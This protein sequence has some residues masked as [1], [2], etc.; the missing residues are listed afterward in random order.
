MMLFLCL[1]SPIQ[2]AVEPPPAKPSDAAALPEAH[3][4]AM[5]GFAHHLDL[6]TAVLGEGQLNAETKELRAELRLNAET[7]SRLTK[8]L[9]KLPLGRGFKEG[10]ESKAL[11][12]CEEAIIEGLAK[13]WSD[14]Q[15]ARFEQLGCQ[16]AGPMALR[17]QHYA[18]RAGLSN[19]QRSDIKEL[20]RSYFEKSAPLQRAVFSARSEREALPSQ[21][22]LNALAKEM[23]GKILALLTEQQRAIWQTFLG[24]GFDW[25]SARRTR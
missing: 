6:F 23:D 12:E 20:V 21:K 4:I 10:D 17:L 13:Q 19:A 24:K 11:E 8:V 9:E 7:I 1:W 18:K 2:A 16:L 14:K 15:Q 25:E 3:G 22:K 5:F